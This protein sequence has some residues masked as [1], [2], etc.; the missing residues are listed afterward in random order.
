MKLAYSIPEACEATSLSRAFLY[1]LMAR[2]DLAFTIIGRRRVIPAKALQALVDGT[3][4]T[5]PPYLSSEE[6]KELK[7]KLANLIPMPIR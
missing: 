1:K 5:W 7:A 4:G 6:I 2:G 3:S